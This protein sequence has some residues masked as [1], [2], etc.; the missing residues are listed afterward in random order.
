MG[1][2]GGGFVG[3]GFAWDLSRAG[4][5]KELGALSEVSRLVFVGERIGSEVYRTADGARYLFGANPFHRE[6]TMP[7]DHAAELLGR[8]PHLFEKEVKGGKVEELKGEEGKSRRVE[9]GEFFDFSQIKGI[10]TKMSGNLHEA[11]ILSAADFISG[12]MALLKRVLRKGEEQV[13]AMIDEVRRYVAETV[14]EDGDVAA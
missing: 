11:G 6:H 14:G 8:F 10:G 1:C 12:E 5:G 13:L 3:S 7:A 9:E 4:A 2:C